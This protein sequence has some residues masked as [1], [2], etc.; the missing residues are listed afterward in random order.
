MNKEDII[1]IAGHA[2]MVGS[3]ISRKLIQSGFN[4]I[5]VKSSSELDLREQKAVNDFFTDCN[6]D[7]VFLAAAK[8]GGIMANNEYR[9]DFI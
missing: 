1:Y 9:A 8:V 7:Y 2:G 4:N 6:P 3:A 5:I